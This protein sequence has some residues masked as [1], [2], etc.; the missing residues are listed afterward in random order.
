[1]Y[2][3]VIAKINSLYGKTYRQKVKITLTFEQCNV[4]TSTRFTCVAYQ[5]K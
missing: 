1:M 3:A 4:G 5:G 2:G